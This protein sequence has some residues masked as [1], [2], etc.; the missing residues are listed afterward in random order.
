MNGNNIILFVD[1][2]FSLISLGSSKPTLQEPR[3]PVIMMINA[4]CVRG[5]RGKIVIVGRSALGSA[6]TLLFTLR[7][8]LSV[9]S[10]AQGQR[11]LI[12][13][14]LACVM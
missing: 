5:C 1:F 13:R 7:L 4:L 11:E 2:C 9:F 3:L 14:K 6:E 10:P 12:D 8:S